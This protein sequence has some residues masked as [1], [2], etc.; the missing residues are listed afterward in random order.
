[1]ILYK[2]ATSGRTTS[3]RCVRCERVTAASLASAATDTAGTVARLLKI[4][5]ITQTA[6][7]NYQPSVHQGARRKGESGMKGRSIPPMP[8]CTEPTAYVG[9]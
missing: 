5:T 4:L 6:T 3:F 2:E 8:I 9:S 7:E 1:M